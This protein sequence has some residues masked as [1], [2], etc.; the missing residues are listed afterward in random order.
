MEV[1]TETIEVTIRDQGPG[2]KWVKYLT[3]DPD[4]AVAEAKLNDAESIEDAVAWLKPRERFVVL[5]DR[6]LIDVLARLPKEP[7]LPQSVAA[8]G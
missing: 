7:P 2:F 6:A 4:R 1:S 8:A 3:F 5:H